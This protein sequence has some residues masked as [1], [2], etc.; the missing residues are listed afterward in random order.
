MMAS[1][2]MPM[3]S[4]QMPMASS[5]MLPPTPSSGSRS[6]GGYSYSP[7]PLPSNE[8]GNP[9]LQDGSGI[10]NDIHL[11]MKRADD[12]AIYQLSSSY[13]P[14]L[15]IAPTPTS[16]RQSQAQRGGYS[17]SQRPYSQSQRGSSQMS[18]QKSQGRG[19]S[20]AMTHALGT[21]QLR[22]LRQSGDSLTW[23]AQEWG[24]S[25]LK[26]V[27]AKTQ[28]AWPDF[29]RKFGLAWTEEDFTFGANGKAV[30]A[31]GSFDVL[32]VGQSTDVYCS[33]LDQH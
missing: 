30:R 6:G 27:L 31:D 9:I 23:Y 15:P 33:D 32:K 16:G 3:G 10:L 8:D 14:G 22:L 13:K 26:A 20:P 1:S 21:W 17:Q 28:L 11:L 24:S 2:Q 12:G 29:E 4:S 7:P 25:E 18:Q 19:S 5:Q